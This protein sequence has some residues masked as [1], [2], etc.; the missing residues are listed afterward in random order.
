MTFSPHDFQ[1]QEV[2]R[3][4]GERKTSTSEALRCKLRHIVGMLVVLV[5]GAKLAILVHRNRCLSLF[6]AGKISASLALV[7]VVGPYA[8][9]PRGT[10]WCLL[11]ILWRSAS[12]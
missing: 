3:A 8:R 9:L 7:C 2:R 4:N 10:S 1:L 6:V 5:P 11:F 12:G